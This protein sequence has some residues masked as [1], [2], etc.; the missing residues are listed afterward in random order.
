MTGVQTCALPILLEPALPQGHFRLQDCVQ[1]DQPVPKM[2]EGSAAAIGI[3]GGAD[4]PTAIFVAAEAE[5]IPAL[6]AYS[7]LHFEPVAPEKVEW[8]AVFLE[9]TKEDIVVELT[10][11]VAGAMEKEE[12]Q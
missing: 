1:N 8:Q 10:E 3:I 4:G 11:E 6:T 5:E 9:K 2:T 12:S 7:A